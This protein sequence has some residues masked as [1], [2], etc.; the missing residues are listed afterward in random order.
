M[1]RMHLIGINFPYHPEV[2]RGDPNAPSLVIPVGPGE[3]LPEFPQ[4]DVQPLAEPNVVPGAQ[5]LNRVPGKD[6]SHYAYVNTAVRRNLYR[7]SLR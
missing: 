1:E 5:S 7:M 6:L 2:G 4:G 3:S